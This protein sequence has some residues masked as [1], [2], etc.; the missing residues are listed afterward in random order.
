MFGPEAEEV[1]GLKTGRD[2]RGNFWKK[3]IFP[4]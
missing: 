2:P 4:R 1:E 3:L